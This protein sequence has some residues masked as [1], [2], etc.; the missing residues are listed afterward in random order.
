MMFEI[1]TDKFAYNNGYGL[2]VVW[3]CINSD[4]PLFM[5]DEWEGSSDV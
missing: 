3:T 5:V 1:T 2:K 4:T